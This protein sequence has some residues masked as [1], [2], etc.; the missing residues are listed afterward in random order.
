MLSWFPSSF[1]VAKPFNLKK[2]LP[3]KNFFAK[4]VSTVYSVIG[5]LNDLVV[6]CLSDLERFF[7]SI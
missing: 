6:G 3:F 1:F 4:I 2:L 7:L 5:C